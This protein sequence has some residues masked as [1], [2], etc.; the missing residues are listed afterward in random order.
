MSIVLTSYMYFLFLQSM[1]GFVLVSTQDGKLL[2]IS[3][4]VTEY[5]GHSMVRNSKHFLHIYITLYI[6]NC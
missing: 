3:E 1:E 6:E 4:N 5:L 2:Y